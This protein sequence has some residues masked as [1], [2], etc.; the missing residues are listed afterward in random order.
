MKNMISLV[1]RN[2]KIFFRTKGNIILASLSV[3]ILIGLHIIIFRNMYTDS[4]MSNISQL[5]LTVEREKMSW[6]VDSLM[7]S[8]ILPIGAVTIS[9]VAL[10][11]MV[12]D[13]ETNVLSD[14]LVSPVK[15]SSLLVSYLVSS[16]LV[17]FTVLL[18]FI[19]L[20]EVYFLAMYGF[21]F[22]LV[23]FLLI[24]L[25][26]VGSLIFSNVF[27]L[28]IISFVKTQQ[29]LGAVGTILGT[30]LGFL[31]GAYVP[32]GMFGKTVGDIFSCL[33]FLQMTVLS[34]EAFLYELESVTPLTHEMISGEL[35]RSFG[36]ELWIGDN[37]IPVWAVIL[38][39]SGITLA[40]LV[41][42]IIRFAKMKK[43]D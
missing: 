27:M 43:S 13:R 12:A 29:S 23:Q 42:L 20:Y 3:L 25:N 1:K 2:T 9:L 39:L 28:L 22:S 36:I 38:I 16:F 34:R 37:L 24:L 17:G 14:F 18:V 33:P 11:L 8:A 5:G 41:C 21:G 7:L 40:M 26:T 35:A 15:R 32:V 4:W 6:F 30:M 19:G 31:C 10:G